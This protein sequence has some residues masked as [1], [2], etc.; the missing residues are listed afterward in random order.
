MSAERISRRRFATPSFDHL[1]RMT[2]DTGLLEHALGRIPRRVEGYC[3]DDNARALW[4]VTEWLS[5]GSSALSHEDQAKL[6]KL[7]EIYMAFLLWQ[8]PDD[9]WWHNNVAYD[10][11]P[12]PEKKIQ[13][14][15]CQGRAIWAV[16]DAWVR[17]EGTMPNTARVMVQRALPTLR[18][19][20]SRRGQAFAMAACAHL[21]DA[22][23]RGAIRLPDSWREELTTHM[24]N[25]ERTMNE[26]FRNFS[27]DN[28]RWFEPA[29]TYSNGVLPWAMLRTYQVTRRS[30]TLRNGL[31]SLSFLLEKMTAEE[32]WL[33]P[34]G[35]D[36]WGTAEN[37]SQWDQ[38]PLE[39]FKLALALEE[40]ARAVEFADQLAAADAE[41]HYV[42]SGAPAGSAGTAPRT[43][44][45]GS[46]MTQSSGQH[47]PTLYRTSHLRAMRDLCLAWFYGENDKRMPMCDPRD[48][49]CCDGLMEIG[50]NMN[51][52]AESTISY[53]MTEALCRRD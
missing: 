8:Q 30:E 50:P 23:S 32:G 5:L 21:L 1:R 34:V 22:G 13:S 12:E 37:V 36:G 51:C 7:A 10:R 38:Q 43:G 29:M 14:H 24:E 39:M 6:T 4:V 3:T 27:D 17:L 41:E 9:G 48:G 33:R 18:Q 44:G 35:N 2:D 49:S 11:T 40:A 42:T 28:W 19:V 15:D 52:G 20:D 47:T 46:G 53:L 26:Q 16:A 45:V 31:E 25:F